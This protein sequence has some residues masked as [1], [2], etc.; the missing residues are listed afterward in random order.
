MSVK[1]LHAGDGYTYLL[2]GIVDGEGM[3]GA[4]S[5]MTRYYAES[6][7]PPGRWMGSG[8]AGLAGG[9]GL[10]P[11]SQVSEE[12]M[13]RL[14]KH[15]T[16]PASG[17]LL[18][19]RFNRPKGWRERVAARVQALPSSLPDAARAAR[20]AAIEVEEH[21]RPTH[22]PV[23]GFDCVFS[24][25]KSV[26]VLWALADQGL[27]EQIS[28]AHYD[29]VDEVLRVME[30]DVARTRIGT[31]GVAQV[32]TRGLIAAAFDHYDSRTGDPQ[33]H[34]HVVVAN[35]VQGPDGRWRTLDSR[36][37]LFPSV[38]AMSELYD[39]LIADRLT[40]RIGV[41]WERRGEPR[42]TKN[43]SWEI[44]G[45]SAELI[46][47]FSQR[48]A[49]I[50]PVKDELI[51]EW[52]R[53]HGREPD[54]VTV[55]RLRQQATY[56]TRPAKELRSLAEMTH[57][58]RT[59]A[60]NI[61]KV[62]A[63]R[64]AASLARW[65]KARVRRRSLRMDDVAPELDEMAAAA[66]TEL[67]EERSTWRTWNI[68]A[69]AARA[70]M[71]YRM[72]SPADRDA[73]IAAITRRVTAMSIR[74]TPPPLA[75]TPRT[76]L[77]SDG[78]SAFSR[79]HG[80]VYT[81]EAVLA[82]EDR[83]QAASAK[84]TAPGLKLNVIERLV[85]EPTEQGFVLA[86][87]QATA[88]TQ[89]ATSG[90]C[91]DVL[92]GPAGTGK[93]TAL[94]ALRAAWEEQHGSGSVVGLAPSAA[95]A[96]ILGESLGITTEN[97]AKWLY[98]SSRQRTEN[99]RWLF[100]PGQ[101]II[102]DEAS[103]AGTLAL[104]TLR[105][106]AE[107]AG[108]KLLLVGDWAQLSAV[109]AGGAFGM[110][111]RDRDLPPELT[112]VRRFTAEWERAASVRLRI[113]DVDVIDTYLEQGRVHDGSSEDMVDA[114]YQAWRADEGA[115]L[116]SVLIA[117]DRLTVRE[118]NERAR[119]DL[120][121]SG[122]VERGGTGLHDGTSAGVGDRIVTRRNDRYL[123]A[124][125]RSW[126]KN[127]DHW[128]VRLRHQD[129]SL[130]VARADGRGAAITLPTAYVAEDVELAYATTA[131][132]A[133]G[134]TVDTAHAIV[135]EASATRE[136]LYVSMT[137]GKARNTAY[138]VTD[139]DDEFPSDESLGAR[140]ALTN[141]MRRSGAELSARET[142][143]DERSRATNIARLAAE[144]ET[145]AREAEAHHWEGILS[146]CQ[147]PSGDDVTASPSYAGLVAA[148]R[149][150]EA[151]GLQPGDLLPRIAAA[152]E[153]LK[154]ED[155]LVVLRD[156]LDQ[157]ID[158]A[159]ETRSGGASTLIVGLFARSR[160]VSD[161]GMRTALDERAALI[162]IRARMLVHAAIS[163]NASWLSELGQLRSTPDTRLTWERC[164]MTIAAYREYHGITG[165]RALAPDIGLDW[166]HRVHRRRA[167]RA[168][169]DALYSSGMK[170][171]TNAPL[172]LEAVTNAQ[173]ATAGRAP[174]R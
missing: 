61:L 63:P 142:I 13:E 156:R 145:I 122:D 37:S 18:G 31:N 52:R 108:A 115:G 114:A 126:V 71:P 54:D 87:D 25:P 164:A 55:L 80:D 98:E 43:Q 26:S 95:A 11:G 158:H 103:L 40:V 93:T 140:E 121:T 23:S 75:S 116:R 32:D 130:T 77:R 136:A 56:M 168:L 125:P 5:P 110:L 170:G 123:A 34:T 86:E 106:Q 89:V 111:V 159:A 3:T 46:G 144:Y 162:E 149:A 9:D 107:R 45:V 84:C 21:G 8:L 132:R 38:V 138:V 7:H 42:K 4:I 36:G 67:S 72:K 88:I 28:Q 102:V 117:A 154:A 167:E 97:T 2:R 33:L 160:H 173:V 6:G 78:T 99:A 152:D 15:G 50:Q 141:I 79:T 76:F 148:M 92:V 104:D 14:F 112:G 135:V 53:A 96:E 151:R 134:S 90:R 150:A 62:E 169:N 143:V 51:S 41:G 155:P 85:S 171:T 39:T 58:W 44:D 94:A 1:A 165:A 127:G 157:I 10:T 16:D 30:R 128:T 70:S 120:V 119:A 17:E 47:M 153:L 27:R 129:G 82:A 133:Q 22:R 166:T 139:S 81:S 57:E 66:F 113:G 24:P 12:Q 124:G 174:E 147:L 73:L 59:R 146:T 35:R 91:I 105:E 101:L 68:R 172:Q 60:A 49:N 19:R 20:A 83:L 118:L 69:A 65:G 100:K 64:W 137:R 74:I 163:K 109:D 161:P 48:S 131:H 29:A